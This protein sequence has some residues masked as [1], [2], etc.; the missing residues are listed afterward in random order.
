M[1]TIQ[2][3]GV[4]PTALIS[5]IAEQVK[6]ELL[7]DLQNS[8]KGNSHRY[9]STNE[10]CEEFGITKPTIYDWKKRGILKAYKL[11]ARVYYRFDEIENAMITIN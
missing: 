3:I 7:K 6:T 11:G 8:I 10:V 2:F 4:E 5:Q 1:E 9:L